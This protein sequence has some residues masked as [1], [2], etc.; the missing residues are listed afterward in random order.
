MPIDGT[1]ATIG[2]IA[3]A[4][5]ACETG[6]SIHKQ[7]TQTEGSWLYLQLIGALQLCLLAFPIYVSVKKI[8]HGRLHKHT[9]IQTSWHPYVF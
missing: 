8:Q 5:S 7:Q 9:D 4:L 3:N 6:T 1:V 2:Q